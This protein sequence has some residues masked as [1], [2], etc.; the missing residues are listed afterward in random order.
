M[1]TFSDGVISI[2]TYVLSGLKVEVD[3]RVT[4]VCVTF[5]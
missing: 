5:I 2:I 1:E 3:G 4:E